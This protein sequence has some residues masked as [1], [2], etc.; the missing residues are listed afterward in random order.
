MAYPFVALQ[1]R[2]CRIG[3]RTLCLLQGPSYCFNNNEKREFLQ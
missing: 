3:P 1:V 2:V